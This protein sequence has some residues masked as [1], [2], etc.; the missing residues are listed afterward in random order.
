MYHI[1]G[2]EYDPGPGV[3]CLRVRVRGGRQGL[4]KL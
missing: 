4:G 2:G 3:T 1:G